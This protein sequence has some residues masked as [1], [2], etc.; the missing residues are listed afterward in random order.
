MKKAEGR[1]FLVV[2]HT[3]DVGTEESQILLS[4]ERAKTIVN[5]LVVRGVQSKQFIYQ[6]N[7]GRNPV[8][9]NTS[10]E[11]RAQNRRVEITILD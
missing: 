4:R 3:A 1:T 2:G 8:A 5:E 11:G 10:P 6:G 7:G 9:P